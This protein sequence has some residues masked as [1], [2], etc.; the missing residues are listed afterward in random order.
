MAFELYKNDT[1]AVEPLEYLPAAPGDYVSGQALTVTDGKL[2]A[3]EAEEMGIPPYICHSTKTI[4]EAEGADNILAVTH[5]SHGSVYRATLESAEAGAKV[6]VA[7]QVK[8]GGLS[9]TGDGG[10]FVLSYVDGTEEG[11]YVLGRFVPQ[12]V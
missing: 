6:G 2:A 3:I 12:T 5:T 11:D 1:G 7:M 4:E 9:P 8:S 10:S